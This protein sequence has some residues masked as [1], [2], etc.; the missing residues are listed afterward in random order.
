MKQRHG[1]VSN[2]SSSSFLV[3]CNGNFDEKI[4]SVFGI[5]DHPLTPISKT[6]ISILQCGDEIYPENDS[7]FEQDEFDSIEE[8]IK[9]F[10]TVKVISVSSEI[11]DSQYSALSTLIRMEPENILIDKPDM[12]IDYL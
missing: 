5:K 4:E 12:R 6:I 1:F 3:G 9:D 2:S 7:R 10:H 8:F 11:S